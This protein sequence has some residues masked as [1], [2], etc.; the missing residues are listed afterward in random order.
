[1]YKTEPD[2]MWNRSVIEGE[3]SQHKEWACKQKGE[4]T[5]YVG[6]A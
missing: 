6:N 1:M 3:T 5:K 2:K 4:E